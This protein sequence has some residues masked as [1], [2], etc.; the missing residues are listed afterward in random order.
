[1]LT[2]LKILARIIKEVRSFLPIVLV[3]LGLKKSHKAVFK[4]GFLLEVNRSNWSNF[5]NHVNFFSLLPDAKIKNGLVE[6]T[7]NNK[8]LTITYSK[9]GLNVI[10]EVFGEKVYDKFFCQTD[11][12]NKVVVDIGA[13]IGDTALYFALRGAK[14]VFAFEPYPYFHHLAEENIERNNLKNICFVVNA[15]LGGKKGEIII[16]PDYVSNF[17]EQARNFSRGRNVPVLTLQDIVK[18]YD[19]QNGLLKMDCEGCEYDAILE[20]PSEIIR[21]FSYIFIEYHQG[22]K[23]LEDKMKGAGFRTN[24]TKPVAHG[25]MQVGYLWGRKPA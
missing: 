1:M 12:E 21:R 24:H 23:S 15:A 8:P 16:P 2:R 17:G 25:D 19:I 11:L 7:Y 13:S 18:Q 22:F 6:I 14:K 3:K 10:C 4:N 9:A 5:I 20:T